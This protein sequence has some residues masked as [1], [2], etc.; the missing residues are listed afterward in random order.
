M[1]RTFTPTLTLTP[2][3]LNADTIGVFYNGGWFLRLNNS[4]G[5]ADLITYFGAASDLPVVGDWNNDGFDT[6]GLYRSSEGRYLLS[7]SNTAPS[8]S[9][10]FTFGNP[11]DTPIAGHW[12]ALTTGSGVGVYRNSNGILYL[13]RAKTTGFDDYYMVFGN[14]GDFGVAGDW[15]NDGFDNIGVYRPSATQW[16]L[17]NVNGN[18]ITFS[19]IDFA[20]GIGSHR[21]VVGD[22]N[23][24]GV[25]TVGYYTNTGNF[26]LHSTLAT[27]GLDNIF[28]FGPNGG[29]PVAGK[30]TVSSVPPVSGVIQP[31]GGNPV[32]GGSDGSD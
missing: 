30:W 8:I 9:Y 14:P 21:P 10:D 11:G 24:D 32:N 6:I 25:S 19:N 18:G 31:V 17:S 20:W 26:V 29:L 12:D 15:N 13:K 1:T 27:V 22:W 28:N 2:I 23:G 3:P 7:D 16:F 5:A 4:S